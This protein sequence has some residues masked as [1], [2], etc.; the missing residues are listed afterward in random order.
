MHTLYKG[1]SKVRPHSFTNTLYKYNLL[2]VDSQGFIDGFTNLQDFMSGFK[3]SQLFV[4][5]RVFSPIQS[6]VPT[7]K[8]KKIN[9]CLTV[10]LL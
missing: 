2:L 7:F 3:N 5:Y 8:T 4:E 9:M 1:I 10:G 6:L